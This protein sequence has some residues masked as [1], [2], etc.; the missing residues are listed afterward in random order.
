[1]DKER[2][3]ALVLII[4]IISLIAGAVIY[5]IW[6]G[7]I[8]RGTLLIYGDVPFSVEFY[9]GSKHKCELSPCEIVDKR[10]T[11]ELILKK[12]G[13][14]SVLMKADIKLWRKNEISIEFKLIPYLTKAEGIPEITD[15]REYKVI[16]EEGN[17]MQKLIK[18]E[19]KAEHAIVYFQKEIKEPRVFGSKN[20]AL[21]L[22]KEGSKDV[23][24]KIDIN[25][26]GREKIENN[27]LLD[28]IAGKWSK[29][30]KYFAYER[31]NLPYI[32]L[33]DEQGVSMELDL[34]VAITQYAWTKN[35]SLVF[36]T[37]QDTELYE[38]DY[39]KISTTI[40]S[41]G[42]TLGEYLVSENK[43]RKIE[44]LENILN[45]PDRLIPT[46]NMKLIYLTSGGEDYKIIL[47]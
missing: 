39:V 29:D 16:F 22:G 12:E 25:N 7:L 40:A 5:S 10:G 8:N 38:G 6:G 43:Y 37:G 24:Y 42:F 35:D 30:G 13:Y 2:K 31:E 34:V 11:K 1:M 45:K 19:D 36:V 26:N 33:M 18:A 21:V 41:L 23:A 14:E 15:E 9:G 3:K 27:N 46:G 44:K 4:F 47:E 28:A 32:W 20:Y 17:K